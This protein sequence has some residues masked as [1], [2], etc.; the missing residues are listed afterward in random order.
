[1]TR[2]H[3]WS[4][5]ASEEALE[6][7]ARVSPGGVHSNARQRAKPVPLF[8]D[9]ASGVHLWDV[10]G[11]QYI[12]FVLG[13][14][15]MFLGHSHPVVNAAVAAALER[16]QLFAGQHLGEVDLAEAL[17][18]HIPCAEQVR[19]CSTGTEAIQAAVRVARAAPGRRRIVKFEGH[20]HGWADN[21]F[22]GV[23]PAATGSL[24]AESLGQLPPPPEDLTVLRWNNVD[25]VAEELKH[26]DVAAVL[27]EPIAV[28]AAVI[29][30]EPGYL[31]DVRRL[32]DRA[33]TLLIF[34]E[35]VTGF[36]FGMGGAQALFGVIPDLATFGKAMA[37]GFPI[38]GVA[39][40]RTLFEEVSSGRTVLSGTFNGNVASVTA[41]LA[42]LQVLS[43]RPELFDQVREVGDHLMR[44]VASLGAGR[45]IVQGYPELFWVGFG[46]NQVRSAGDLQTFDQDAGMRLAGEL[47]KRGVYVTV[48][49][50]W[51]LSPVHTGDDAERAE[52]AFS[53]SLAMIGPED[54]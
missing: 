51:Y 40:R 11:N 35:I 29:P 30:P 37:S 10:D 53:E 13:Q 2:S 14:G 28:N 41:A 18:A 5:R 24:A 17:C 22:I 32:C 46:S 25:A 27:M 36:R 20:Y 7:A 43:S 33:G 1:V 6:R 49:G 26:G 12:D 42:T 39:G 4:A 48:R 50:N 54:R 19:L 9:R 8:F 3:D 23:R 44:A 31:A 21:V 16:G 52:S 15:P 38:A 34:D 47:V 45:V